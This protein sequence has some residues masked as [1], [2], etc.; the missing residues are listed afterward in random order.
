MSKWTEAVLLVDAVSRPVILR[1][2]RGAETYVIVERRPHLEGIETSGH[3][4]RPHL[5]P[6]DNVAT[7][8]GVSTHGSGASALVEALLDVL[9]RQRQLAKALQERLCRL[10]F[11]SL[12]PFFRLRFLSCL[13]L[14]SCF[15]GDTGL[16]AGNP[17]VNV[18]LGSSPPALVAVVRG[19]R[20]CSAFLS[21]EM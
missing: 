17:R 19:I 14:V 13:L 2:G 20:R 4:I 7:V 3:D 11:C 21:V 1:E 16:L 5:A 9:G 8:L 18:L 15:S 6:L 12:S 10:H